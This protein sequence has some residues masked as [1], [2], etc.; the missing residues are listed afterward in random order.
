MTGEGASHPSLFEVRRSAQQAPEAAIC[1]ALSSR[2]YLGL[3]NRPLSGIRRAAPARR[4]GSASG[5]GH[6]HTP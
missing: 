1:R 3:G 6:A 4:D 5:S 2:V